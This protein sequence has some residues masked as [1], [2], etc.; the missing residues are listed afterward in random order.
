MPHMVHGQKQN[1]VHALL[2]GLTASALRS[3][4]AVKHDRPRG[5][6]VLMR[7]LCTGHTGQPF[8]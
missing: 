3:R 7:S 2:S 8:C 4:L 5:S 6:Y 1:G